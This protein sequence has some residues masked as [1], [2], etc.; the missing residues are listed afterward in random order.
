MADEKVLK[1]LRK[2]PLFEGLPEPVL[3][4]LSGSVTTHNLEK[5]ELL[6][7]QGDP[8]DALY[9]I[10]YGWVKIVL[11]DQEG[12]E[13]VVNQLGPA[14]IIGE[15]ALLDKRPRSAG[16]VAMTPA[17]LFRLDY[18]DFQRV[19]DDQPR[20][21]LL[22]ARNMSERLRFNMT[23]LQNAVEWSYQVAKGDYSFVIDELEAAH[24]TIID[25]RKPD[26]ARARELLRAFVEMVREVKRR[27]DELKQQL[28]E[29]KIDVDRAQS[30]REV[31]DITQGTFF[32]RLKSASGRRGRGGDKERG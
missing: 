2:L 27:E 12:K 29:F 32:R 30:Q 20:L 28:K 9:I 3:Q 8:G 7:R 23:Y 1:Y 5:D 18:D 17:E 14:E 24:A 6:F 22:M 16:V 21:A 4:E 10:R 15:M 26:D 25:S 11:T 19:V 13:L 31:E